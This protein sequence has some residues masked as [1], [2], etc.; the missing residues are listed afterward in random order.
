M[1]VVDNKNLIFDVLD[2]PL[3]RFGRKIAVLMPGLA[4]RAI[5]F[6]PH[7]SALGSLSPTPWKYAWATQN[8][9][10]YHLNKS[11]KHCVVVDE[12][13]L[14]VYRDSGT[15]YPGTW[16]IEEREDG[17][18]FGANALGGSHASIGAVSK[19]GFHLY[20]LRGERLELLN[21]EAIPY[22]VW[23]V[24]REGDFL[25]L[26]GMSH[27]NSDK[28]PGQSYD[29]VSFGRPALIRCSLMGD[30]WEEIRLT[31]TQDSD[32]D[33]FGQRFMDLG[34]GPDL[35]FE[36]WVGS[37]HGS[38][39]GRILLAA[40]ARKNIGYFDHAD[41]ISAN[42]IVADYSALAFVSREKCEVLHIEASARLIRT[43]YT[44]QKTLFVVCLR[45][46]QD[47]QTVAG[48][49]ILDPLS[50]GLSFQK[51]LV[52]GLEPSTS[53][54]SLAAAYFADEGFF[55]ALIC[56]EET[57]FIHS[58]DAVNW[59]VLGAASKIECLCIE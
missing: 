8:R 19:S 36:A 4:L 29:D 12:S 10:W 58:Q 43:L 57:Y 38:G 48:L 1:S 23:S 15:F 2:R 53:F 42:P 33:F 39:Y 22:L 13:S 28:S 56:E 30:R 45:L 14:P 59:V 5:D 11:S 41:E 20:Y 17:A 50:N 25:I 9:L 51:L 34:L 24:W 21:L 54:T 27:R 18:V 55:G 49:H 44:P 47:G 6:G 3:A 7:P 52:E 46:E 26:A 32:G 16:L 31:Q 40:L 37:E 35:Q